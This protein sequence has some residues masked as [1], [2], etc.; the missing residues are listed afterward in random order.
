[1]ITAV[2]VRN[3]VTA[4]ACG[5]ASGSERHDRVVGIALPDRVSPGGVVYLLADGTVLIAWNVGVAVLNELAK[6][7]P[8]AVRGATREA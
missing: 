8:A 2:G 1:V 4:V 6:L 3:F 7:G 5:L